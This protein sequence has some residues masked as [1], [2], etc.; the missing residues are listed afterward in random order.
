MCRLGCYGPYVQMSIALAK[1][2]V[3]FGQCDAEVVA[4]AYADE[5]DPWRGYSPRLFQVRIHVAWKVWVW[6]A[7]NK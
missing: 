5:F 7:G 1:S 6:L 2:L 3:T 4:R